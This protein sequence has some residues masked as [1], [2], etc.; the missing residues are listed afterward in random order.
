MIMNVFFTCVG[1]GSLGSKADKIYYPIQQV[2]KS[3]LGDYG[4]GLSQWFLLFSILGPGVPGHD[5]PE[6][7][8]WKKKTRD[9]D[10]RLVVDFDMFKRGSEAERRNMLI[11]CMRRSLELIEAKN[12]PNFNILALKNDFEQIVADEGWEET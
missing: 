7:V 11:A 5:A 10:M 9:L 8:L 4:D 2:L 3:R 6:R 12:I 1:Q